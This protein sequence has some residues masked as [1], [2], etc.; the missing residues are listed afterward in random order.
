MKRV[1]GILYTI[2]SAE[3]NSCSYLSS[4]AECETWQV[5]LREEHMLM[6]SGQ[7]LLRKYTRK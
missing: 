2:L 7:I 3:F 4:T 5:M 1:I 6:A